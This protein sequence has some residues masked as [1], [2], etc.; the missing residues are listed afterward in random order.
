MEL[1]KKI[2]IIDD[3]PVARMITKK[4]LAGVSTYELAEAG[5]GQEGLSR[6]K[7]FQPDVTFLD[8]TMPVMDGFQTLAEILAIAPKAV[9]IVATADVQMKTISKIMDM[10]A[11]LLLKK[12]L[13]TDAVRKAL[14][15][16]ADYLQMHR[17]E[18]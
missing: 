16:A 7:E 6:F 10:D 11:F 15:Q 1:I 3:S 4:C 18:V 8:L 13:S 17:G 9:V 2:L 5:D 12:P 14:A